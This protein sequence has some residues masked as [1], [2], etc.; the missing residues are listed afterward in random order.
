MKASLSLC[1]LTGS[2]VNRY[3]NFHLPNNEINAI[4]KYDY[5]AV[6]LTQYTVVCICDNNYANF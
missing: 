1:K 4:G 3:Y 2:R 6:A 5:T